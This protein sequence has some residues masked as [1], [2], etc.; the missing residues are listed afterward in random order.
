MLEFALGFPLI[1][2]IGTYRDFRFVQHPVQRPNGPDEPNAPET[3]RSAA[4]F[5]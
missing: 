4:L 5:R 3:R 2:Y 1:S